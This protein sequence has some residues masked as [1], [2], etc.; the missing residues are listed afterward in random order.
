MLRVSADTD[1]DTDKMC[2]EPME[3]YI[4]LGSV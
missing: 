2:T 3:I 1:T 4:G